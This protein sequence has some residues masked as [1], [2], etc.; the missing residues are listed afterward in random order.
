MPN[1]KPLVTVCIFAFNHEK[2]IA[3]AIESVLS[4]KTNFEFEVIVGEDGSTDMTIE[5]L[6]RFRSLNSSK[7]RILEQDQSKK[8]YLN[9]YP[10][11]RWNFINTLS[12][13]RGKY[14]SLL[15]G[16][17]YWNDPFKLQK[18]VDFLE[19]NP[20]F[21]ICF[22]NVFVE[23][24]SGEKYIANIIPKDKGNE[25]VFSIADL[26][27]TNFIH[28]TSALFRNGLI[29]GFPDWFFKSPAGDYPLHMLNARKGLIKY[30]NEPMAVYRSQIGIWSSTS[31]QVQ[32]TNLVKVLDLLI[33]EFK[34]DEMVRRNLT[35]QKYTH[36]NEILLIE[37]EG[38]RIDEFSK[39]LRKTVNENPEFAIYWTE[40]GMN[41]IINDKNEAE[42]NLSLI[43]NSTTYKTLKKIGIFK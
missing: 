35:L 17:D 41:K 1:L 8:I 36:V 7:L 2:Y 9:G 27:R 26:A 38:Q 39:L 13:A 19:A 5:I 31:R 21:A 18:Q 16:D 43:R 22:H 29:E 33:Q 34:D 28:T 11:G 6:H 30:F 40:N 3:Q 32:L 23:T 20:D 37:F 24:K 42:K 14:I 15:D 4:Q 10:T 12:C 25:T